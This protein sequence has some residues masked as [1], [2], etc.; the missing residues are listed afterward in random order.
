M[1]PRKL[2]AGVLAAAALTAAACFPP[3]SQ[4]G[5]QVVHGATIL[6]N[7]G[8]E[9]WSDAKLER[10]FDAAA[11]YWGVSVDALDGYVVI[12][13]D[14]DGFNIGSIGV[15]GVTFTSLRRM[16]FAQARPDCAEMVFVHE[17]GHGGADILNHDDE[18]FEDENIRS[19]LTEA[20]IC[21]Y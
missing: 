6:Y 18:R 5:P 21:R 13:H 2:I 7:P 15:W 16:E 1:S 12:V 8:V 9:R 3:A 19:F 20:G 4:D 14:R 10:M 17:F 11:R